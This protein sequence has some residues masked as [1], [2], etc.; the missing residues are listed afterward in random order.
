MDDVIIVGA[1]IGGLT[2]ALALHRVGVRCRVFEAA[3]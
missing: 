2:L 1:G 3:D